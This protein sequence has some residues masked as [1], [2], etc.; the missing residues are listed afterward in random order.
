MTAS[1]SIDPVRWCD[2]PMPAGPFADGV[3]ELILAPHA[4]PAALMPALAALL[5]PD[6]HAAAARH[7]APDARNRAIVSR[8]LLRLLL[9]RY[10]GAAP[11]GL[12]IATDDQGKPF[13]RDPDATG[14][15][16]AFN[17]A[18]AG[19]LLLFGFARAAIG[20]DIE[21]VRPIPRLDAFVRTALGAGERALHAARPE[22]ERLDHAFRIWVG[23]E[24]LVKR[25]GE[26]IRRDFA[27][28]DLTD[29]D[30]RIFVPQDG[31]IAAVSC[32][33]LATLRFRRTGHI[34]R[35]LAASDAANKR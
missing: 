23:K 17:L 7:R 11:Q 22:E 27:A 3:I 8:A 32:D 28:F 29:G 26:G 2:A 25:S 15:P 6:E 13:V 24:A 34:E 18:H 9:A 20:V 33:G 30:A 14:R 16:L 35:L 10:L 4:A 31:Y 19:D 1:P 21:P 5:T 12:T